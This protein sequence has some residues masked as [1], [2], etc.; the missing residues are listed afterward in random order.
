MKYVV[1]MHPIVAA[2][3]IRGHIVAAVAHAQTIAGWIRKEVEYVRFRALVGGLGPIELICFP[4]LGPF[5]L[6]LLRIVTIN[7]RMWNDTK[8]HEQPKPRSNKGFQLFNKARMLQGIPQSVKAFREW[9]RTQ[10][11][12]SCYQVASA[13]E[14]STNY[15]PRRSSPAA[16]LP[17]RDPV[18]PTRLEP[19]PRYLPDL[20]ETLIHLHFSVVL[21][22]AD[23]P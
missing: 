19:S 23:D 6:E 15:D 21:S 9:R 2:Q 4:A 8:S 22:S 12:A 1:A 10:M 7:H 20:L 18:T 16:H 14:S 5:R 3:H 13:S 11:E 17:N